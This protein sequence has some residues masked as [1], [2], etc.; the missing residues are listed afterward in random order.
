MIGQEEPGKG[1]IENTLGP[2]RRSIEGLEE[3]EA[4]RKTVRAIYDGVLDIDWQADYNDIKEAIASVDKMLRD[5]IKNVGKLDRLAV[6]KKIKLIDI[7]D[8]LSSAWRVLSLAR[9]KAEGKNIQTDSPDFENKYK[10][11]KV[12]E[13]RKYLNLAADLMVISRKKD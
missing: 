7:V 2:K 12:L 8:N 4:Y 1:R 3:L 9:D 5:T 10:Y 6:G 13:C 11:D